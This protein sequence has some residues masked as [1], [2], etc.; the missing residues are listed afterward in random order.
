MK[1]QGILFGLLTVFF[2]LTAVPY[3]YLSRE[4]IGTVALALTAGM[5][6][7]VGYYLYFTARRL[8]QLPEDNEDGE[9]ADIAGEY[10]FYSPH[11]WW[12]LALAG[13]AALVFLGPVFGWWIT[14]I[15]VGF[16]TIALI[17]FVFEYYRGDH[18]H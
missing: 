3:W 14:F 5:A 10:G 2:V 11:S 18:A 8:D 6:A 15:G 4:P 7:L 16:G 1:F 13:S 9:I 12:P 17:G